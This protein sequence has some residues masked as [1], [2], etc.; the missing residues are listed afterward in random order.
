MSGSTL[1][2]RH[3]LLPLAPG[4][5]L[6]EKLAQDMSVCPG[7]QSMEVA[8]EVRRH[9]P[10]T[11]GIELIALAA[12][13]TWGRMAGW[14][15]GH[16]FSPV[17]P[18]EVSAEIRPYVR[19]AFLGD[20][21]LEGCTVPV[22]LYVADDAACL[23][24]ARVFA[25]GDDLHNQALAALL[26]R[27]C[28]GQT[29]P[30]VGA[31]SE[32]A[33]YRLAG[34]P[35]VPP[36]L[37]DGLSMAQDSSRLLTTDRYRGDLHM[38]T[39][40]SDGWESAEKMVRACRERGYRYMAITD[41]SQSLRVANGLSSGR[42][43]A[44]GREIARLRRLYPDI[45]LYH[46]TEVDILGKGELDFADDILA[47]LDL[48]VASIHLGLRQN[49]GRATERLLAAVRSPFVHI[50]GHPSGRILGRRK[51][52]P[53]DVRRVLEA[54]ARHGTA[55][56]CNANPDRLDLDPAWLRLAAETGC[57]VAVDSDAHRP[58]DLDRVAEFGVA[59]A[60]KGWLP[61]DRIINTWDPG[62]LESWIR[63]K[64][65][66]GPSVAPH[67]PVRRDTKYQEDA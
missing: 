7:I 15:A 23:Q 31:E 54:A 56:E 6:G 57:L 67:S 16:S 1:K 32:E 2:M 33:V 40:A 11:G 19:G 8:G 20:T 4:K 50:L 21:A 61:Y 27:A 64:R 35:F 17:P 58:G 62:R 55:V 3:N 14:L 29:K 46:G 66:D 5:Q 45:R 9:E 53:F 24:A 10:M 52:Y 13:E 39:D 34:L 36:E 22:R 65:R 51:G 47:N 41:H 63:K 60:R 38:H 30:A 42:L 28:P 59:N 44:Q 48:V 49:G 37:R 18:D 26:A 43:H 25:T 12:G